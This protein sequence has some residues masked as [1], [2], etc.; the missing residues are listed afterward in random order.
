LRAR[1]IHLSRDPDC[2]V[3]GDTPTIR[4]L[5]A[6]DDVCVTAVAS[7]TAAELLEWRRRGAPH[8]LVDVREAWEHEIRSIPGALLVPMADLD[9]RFPLFPTDRPVV[10]YCQTGVRSGLVTSR[11][12]AR[13]I[14]ARNLFGGVEAWPEE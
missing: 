13:G 1:E 14:D 3:C 6:Y 9:A 10:I 4:D 2:P 7:V 8:V 11:L 5:T 12:R